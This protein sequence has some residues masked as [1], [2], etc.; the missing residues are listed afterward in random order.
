MTLFVTNLLHIHC[1]VLLFL[2]GGE[3][4]LNFLCIPIAYALY[5]VRF[6]AL[7][8]LLPLVLKNI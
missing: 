7:Y 1:Y 4:F 6:N 3:I 8:T 2:S 5:K